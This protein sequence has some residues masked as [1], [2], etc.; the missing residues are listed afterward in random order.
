MVGSDGVV[1]MFSAVSAAV[2]LLLPAA[3]AVAAPAAATAGSHCTSKCGNISIPYPFGVEPGC[4]LPGFNVTCRNSTSGVPELF[5]GDGTLQVLEISIPNATVRINATFAY[6]PG[7]NGTYPNNIATTNRTWSSA[8]GESGPYT[9]GWRNKLIVLGCNVQVIVAGGRGR[10]TLSTCA[11]LCDWNDDDPGWFAPWTPDCSG[12]GCCQANIMAEYSSYEFKALRMNGVPGPNSDAQVWIVDSDFVSFHP[13][14]A[15]WVRP[16][17][18]LP[19][20]LDWSI[21]HT[22]CHGNASSAACHSSHSLCQ[23][24]TGGPQ[25]HHCECAQGYKGNP[26]IPNGCKGNENRENYNIHGSYQMI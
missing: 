11:A 19:A 9:L 20:V 17:G 3:A 13:A 22:T 4:F 23:N 16:S 15:D 21:N 1:T 8:L 10:R 14:Y 6:F 26:Y 5:L 25:A 18:R 24:S 7:S 2:L 12:V